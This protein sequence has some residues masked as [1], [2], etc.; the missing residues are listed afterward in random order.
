LIL[1]EPRWNHK[2]IMTSFW[3]I[4][5]GLML[6]V[7]M[8]LFP[9]GAIQFK[10]IVDNGLWYGRSHHFIGGGIFETLTWLR[11]IGATVFFVGGVIP[12][13][14]FML[15]R[16]NSLK[17]SIETVEDLDSRPKK[18]VETKSQPSQEEVMA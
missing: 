18:P 12:I 6:M 5:I 15:S 8:D 3:S 4:N 7:V 10:A 17:P 2:L 14:W 1:K 16:W 9:A 13:T 11:G